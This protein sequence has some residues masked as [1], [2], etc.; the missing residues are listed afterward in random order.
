MFRKLFK[1]VGR[2]FHRLFK[3]P[4]RLVIVVVGAVLTVLSFGAAAPAY[5]AALGM[6]TVV[7][8]VT[9]GALLACVGIGFEQD[10]LL[11]ALSIIGAAVSIYQIAFNNFG[12][13]RYAG[14]FKSTGLLSALNMSQ[15][16]LQMLYELGIA[17]RAM[18]VGLEIAIV[19]GLQRAIEDNVSVISGVSSVVGDVAGDIAEGGAVIIGGVASGIGDGLG[20]I[21]S[22]L[23]SSPVFWIAAG[24]YLLLRSGRSST[25]RIS[26]ERGDSFG[27]NSEKGALPA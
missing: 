7:M 12:I 18:L 13:V 9:V 6:S 11:M 15:G 10:W 27:K 21:V 3:D 4:L 24:A 8:Q 5:A 20:S 14:M 2:F 22:D 16:T 26:L 25:T 1:E 19:A 17:S 23:T